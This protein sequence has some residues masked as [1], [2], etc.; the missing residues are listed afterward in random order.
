MPSPISTRTNGRTSRTRSAERNHS[1]AKKDSRC[2]GI[3][4]Y[5]DNSSQTRIVNITDRGQLQ[6]LLFGFGGKNEN[7]VEERHVLHAIRL[8]D[9]YRMRRNAL[10]ELLRK[11]RKL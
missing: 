5:K 1:W 9:E 3:S 11:A 4:A 7:D 6:I 10:E 8:R 2:E